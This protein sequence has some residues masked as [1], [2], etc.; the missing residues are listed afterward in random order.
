MRLIHLARALFLLPAMAGMFAYGQTFTSLASFNGV[1]GEFPCCSLLQAT[2]GNFYGT[3]VSGGGGGTV[4][5]VTPAG[6]ITDV[7]DFSA[8]NYDGEPGSGLTQGTDGGLYGTTPTGGFNGYGTAFK[9]TLSGQLTTLYNFFDNAGANPTGVLALGADGNF[10]GETYGLQA[11]QDS[12]S[13]TAFK[14][15]PAGTVTTLYSF[16][17]SN[18]SGGLVL[19]TD[20]NF[21]GT[22]TTGGA[23]GYGAVFR[24]TPA[25]VL[26]TLYSF[27]G[28]SGIPSATPLVQAND[29]ALYGAT[30]AYE[31]SAGV[32]FRITTG[33]AFTTIHTFDFADGSSPLGLIQATDGQLY[34]TTFSGTGPNGYGSVFRMTLDGHLTTL[35]TFDFTQGAYPVGLVQATNGNFYG[36]TQEGGPSN[37]GTIFTVSTG[38]GPFVRVLPTWG[39][40]GKPVRILG[41]NL[42]GATGVSFNGTPAVFTIV[43]ATEITTTVP[44]GAT[45][46]KVEV[47]GSG[48]A[49]LSNVAFQVLR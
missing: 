49:L 32:V 40:V 38:L 26:A 19:A 16:N 8:Y 1:N 31:A 42:A 29:G 36:A 46:G 7:Y 45:T 24:I 21:Y 11:Y 10:Y 20:G 4:F 27:D 39:A 12:Y 18:P 28:T 2:D 44:A 35:H 5:K 25:G 6:A 15:T 41:T 34:G 14:M 37:D 47:T 9:I 23:Y 13:G 30:S 17:N 3:T 22:T 43:S 33:G 48:S